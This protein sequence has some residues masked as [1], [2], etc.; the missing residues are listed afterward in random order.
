MT[1]NTHSCIGMDGKLSPKRIARVI[2]RH[3]PDIIALQELDVGRS[4][5]GGMDQAHLIAKYLQMEFH[6]HP[7]IRMEDGLYG[8]AVLTHLPMRPVKAN[9]LPGLPNKTHIEPRGAIWVA[10]EVNGTEIQ[11]I[12]THLGLR[13]NERQAQARALLGADWL[14]HPDCREPVI[15]CGDFNALPSSPV[16]LKL[17]NRLHDVQIKL[18]SHIP[19]STFFGRY[20][21]ARIDHVFVDPGI[22]VVNIEVPGTEL[23]NVA[24]D[25]LPLIAELR[26]PGKE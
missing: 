23:A 19:K 7:T 16:C 18:D 3:A 8:N 6:F 13:P 9:R 25:H 11:F 24:S 22:K 2:A 17:G 5:T 15:L 21:F 20:P 1:Y 26:I 12:T 10:I 4:R 14:S